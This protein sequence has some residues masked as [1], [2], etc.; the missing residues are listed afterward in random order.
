MHNEKTIKKS[1][2]LPIGPI[3]PALKEPVKFNFTIEGERIVDVDVE[4]GQVHRAIEWAGMRRNPVQ[5]LYIAERVCGICSV[6]HPFAFCM[7]MEDAAKIEVPIKAEYIRVI[8]AELERIHSHLLWAGVAAHEIG[9]DS[10]FYLTWQ[11]REEILDVIEYLTGNRINKAMF[12]IGGVRRD[13]KKEQYPRI[14][15]ALDAYKNNFNKLGDI[16]LKDP[17]IKA[18]TRD[19]GILSKKDALE[20]CAVGPTTRASGVKKDVRQD[21]SYSAYADL[22]IEAITPDKLTGKVVGDVYDRIIVRL[23]EVKQSIEII[24]TCLDEM[25]SGDILAIE[26]IPALLTN[27]KRAVGEGVGRHEAPRGEVIHYVKLTGKEFPYAWKIRAPTYNNIM[28]WKPMLVGGQIADIPIVVAST[29]PCM[30]CTNRV[31]M[32]KNNKKEILTNDQLHKLSI[33]KTEKIKNRHRFFINLAIFFI[34][35]SYSL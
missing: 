35:N 3:H 34:V 20:L 24:E 4:L 9:F 8:T 16:F 21:Q 32:I 27:L 14:K 22:D 13:I 5:I 10:V 25:P 30:S 1:Y 23:L 29:D 31:T 28:P 6:S 33:K 7:A 15:K 26:K 18:R 17:T 2:A 19:T 12:M 11:M